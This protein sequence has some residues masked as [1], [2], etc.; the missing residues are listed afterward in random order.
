MPRTGAVTKDAAYVTAR[1]A[2]GLP[3]DGFEYALSPWDDLLGGEQ[4]ECCVESQ[5][6]PCHDDS[7]GVVHLLNTDLSSLAGLSHPGMT[8]VGCARRQRKKI[9]RVTM[10]HPA[11]FR[12]R[13]RKPQ[14]KPAPLVF[15]R[16]FAVSIGLLTLSTAAATAVEM[17]LS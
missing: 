10:D 16:C 17:H 12:A 5:V 6:L 1:A 8:N 13:G 2:E 9:G 7:L 14:L 15:S 4:P 3:Q 11:L